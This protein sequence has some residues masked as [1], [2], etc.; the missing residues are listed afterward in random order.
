MLN[1]FFYFKYLVVET[2]RL[3]VGWFTMFFED[4]SCMQ[5]DRYILSTNTSSIY[6]RGFKNFRWIILS[7]A[8]YWCCHWCVIWRKHTDRHTSWHFVQSFGT[9]DFTI[10]PPIFWR[11]V[12]N[13]LSFLDFKL[14]RQLK[15]FD[16]MT[17]FW[18]NI[19]LCY[20]FVFT[21]APFIFC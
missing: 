11:H 4:V 21:T 9:F 15:L 20:W 3:S 6:E 1:H 10:L 17:L 18:T 19:V 8:T 7:F 13:K 12:L 14:I 16:Y 5:D 2:T